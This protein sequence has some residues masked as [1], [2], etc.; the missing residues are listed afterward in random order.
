M[1]DLTGAGFSEGVGMQRGMGEE[2]LGACGSL[3]LGAAPGTPTLAGTLPHPGSPGLPSPSP[4]R[5]PRPTGPGV[6]VGEG[7]G[8]GDS[9]GLGCQRCG[10]PGRGEGQPPSQRPHPCFMG[11][12]RRGHWAP[13]PQV[14]VRSLI[15]PPPPQGRPTIDPSIHARRAH[16]CPWG[17][18]LNAFPPPHLPVSF[19]A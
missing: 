8:G 10:V 14:R 13:K 12:A 19:L 9:N 11:E 7:S 2:G 18:V 17:A 3:V 4:A 16:Q 5:L 15:P 1:K 6:P